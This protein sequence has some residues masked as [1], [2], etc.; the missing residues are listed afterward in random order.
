LAST[1]NS[2]RNITEDAMEHFAQKNSFLSGQ[3][4]DD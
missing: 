4:N 3:L 1:E 2:L